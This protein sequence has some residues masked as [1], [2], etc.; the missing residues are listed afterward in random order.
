MGGPIPDATVTEE[1][2]SITLQNPAPGVVVSEAS[3]HA[4]LPIGEKIV[5]F[6][7]RVMLQHPDG[8]LIFHDWRRVEGYD[9]EVRRL[10]VEAGKKDREHVRAINI[11]VRSKVLAMGLSVAGLALGTLTAYRDGLAFR[12]ALE[13]AVESRGSF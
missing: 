7:S 4:S 13:A 9:T 11:L 10:L 6:V 1:Q 8:A 5:E 3:G 12:R 2:G